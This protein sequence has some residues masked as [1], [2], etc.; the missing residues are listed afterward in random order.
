MYFTD[1]V[2]VSSQWF[3]IPS[4]SQFWC[5][6]HRY[7]ALLITSYCLIDSLCFCPSYQFNVQLLAPLCR[8]YKLKMYNIYPLWHWRSSFKFFGSLKT[9]EMRHTATVQ[10]VHHWCKLCTLAASTFTVQYVWTIDKLFC[11]R[12]TH[13]Y[14]NT[15]YSSSPMVYKRC[16]IFYFTLAKALKRDLPL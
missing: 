11:S 5:T 1:I 10:N 14:Y 8:E 9:T 6:C 12:W 4:I 2:Y 15:C 3:V 16:T 7:P 13:S